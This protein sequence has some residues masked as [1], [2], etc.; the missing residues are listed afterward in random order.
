MRGWYYGAGYL[1]WGGR[2]IEWDWSGKWWVVERLGY[3]DVV[4]GGTGVLLRGSL[5][6]L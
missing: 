2:R 6:E 1:F 4:L 5:L 3:G